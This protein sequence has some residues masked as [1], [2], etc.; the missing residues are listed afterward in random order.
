[1]PLGGRIDEKR[2]QDLF[3]IRLLEALSVIGNPGDH[4]SQA[5]EMPSILAEHEF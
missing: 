1:M 5:V 4:P 3:G 2:Y